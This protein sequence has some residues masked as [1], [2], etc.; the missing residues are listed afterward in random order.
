MKTAVLLGTFDGLHAGHRA[1]I[2]AAQG[3]NRV[4][5]TFRVPPKTAFSQEKNMLMLP[6]DR[7][8]L[9]KS[10]GADRVLMAEFG[11][12]KD[13]SPQA[14]F[15]FL[16]S[17]YSPSLVACGFDYRFGKN[18]SGDTALLAELCKNAGVS[19]TC[20]PQV[21]SNGEGVSSTLIRKLVAAGEFSRANEFL[22][23]DFSFTAP[24]LGGDRRGRTI[25]FPT[26]NQDYPDL[27]VKPRF[28][29]Y[30]SLVEWD[31]ICLK[32]VTNIGMRPTF[33]KDR[34]TCETHIPDFSGDL[35]G[36][37]IKLVPKRFIRAEQRFNSLAEL[38]SAI[39]GDLLSVSQK[40]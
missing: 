14:Y 33:K 18:A 2:A 32:G 19:F 36:K 29:V 22:Y 30:E 37:K 11:D 35:Y 17:Q 26:I 34:V 39:Q 15:D 27:L 12:I 13:M 31:G 24:V 38:K 8:E 20:C 6:E 7:L 28:G 5:C 16:L 3:Y 21:L 25:G 23:R 40:D 4:A 9:L 10:L 1:V